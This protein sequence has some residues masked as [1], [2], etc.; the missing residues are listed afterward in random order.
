MTC[1]AMPPPTLRD[2]IETALR[3]ENVFFCLIGVALGTAVGVLP[4]IGPTAT[5]ALLLPV[6]FNFEPV[7]ALIMLAGCASPP[8]STRPLSFSDD[9][10]RTYDALLTI[11]AG[12]S[13]GVGVLLLGGAP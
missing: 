3:L 10:A 4:G 9:D 6:T 5:I 1:A 7:T 13:H 2:R 11:P 12:R 8:P